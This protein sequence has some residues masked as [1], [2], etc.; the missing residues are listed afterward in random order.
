[1]QVKLGYVSQGREGLDARKTVFEEI[2][3]GAETM[4]LG[5][6]E[7]NVRAYVSTFNLK[8]KARAARERTSTR[9]V[10]CS[11]NQE[12]IPER[13]SRQDGS[14]GHNRGSSGAIVMLL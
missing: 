13:R 9:T 10:A 1:M 12:R 7:V 4:V 8:G 6:R 2:A 5:S 3:Q 14:C 11:A